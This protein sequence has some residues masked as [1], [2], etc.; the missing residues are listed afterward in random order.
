MPVA[1]GT[2]LLVIAINSATAFAAR[3]QAGVDL[4]WPMLAAV[5]ALAVLGSVVGARRADR[6]DPRRLGRAFAVLLIV[7]GAYL[8]LAN[9]PQLVTGAGI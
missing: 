3:V 1:V 2:S 6:L 7:V 9:V 4:D 8:A 5:T